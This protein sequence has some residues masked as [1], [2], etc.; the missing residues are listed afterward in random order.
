MSLRI[1]V[2][3]FKEFANENKNLPIDMLADLLL[4]G[5]HEFD[6]VQTEQNSKVNVKEVIEY[7]NSK[8]GKKFRHTTNRTK[9]LIQARAKEGFSIDDFKQ[10]IDNQV[11]TWDGEMRQYLRPETLFGTKMDSYVNNIPDD[12]NE[13][14]EGDMIN[15]IWSN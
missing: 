12:A 3:K 5:K 10:A 7:L 6:F 13:M 8:T 4:K 2:T 9:T 1:D 15:S 11:K 14:S